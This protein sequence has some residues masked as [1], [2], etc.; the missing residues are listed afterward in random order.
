LIDCPHFV[1]DRFAFT[2]RLASPYLGRL[3]MWLVL[4]GA[5]QLETSGIRR[6]IPRGGTIML[7]GVAGPAHWWAESQVTLLGVTIPSGSG[8][9]S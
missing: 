7:P 1:L 5:A 2:G 6:L 9:L 4:E 8:S 3:S